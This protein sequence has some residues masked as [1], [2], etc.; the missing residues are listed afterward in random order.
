[1]S[2]GHARLAPSNKRWP[3][4]PGSVRE[5]AQYPD[6]A[7]AAAVDGTG[8]HLL[9]ELC[10]DN[11][12]RPE[13]Y[14]GQVIGDGHEDS[15]MGWFVQP[16]RIKRVQECLDYLKRRHAEL[17]TEYPGHN[18]NIYAETHSDPGG[19][20]G[21]DDWNGTCDVT[22]VVRHSMTAECVFIEVVDYKDG[23]EFVSPHD[24]SQLQSYLGGK[25]RPYI[26]SGPDLVR[27]LRPGNINARMT[28]VQPKT[29]PSVRYQDITVI[30]FI[31][32]LEELGAAAHRTDDPDAPLIPDDKGGK[33][34]CRW[35][36]HRQNCEALNNKPLEKLMDFMDTPPAVAGTPAPTAGA[37]GA[38]EEA[39]KDL[40]ALTD[41]RLSE[42][43]DLKEHTIGLFN[44]VDQEIERRLDAGISVPGYAMKPGRASRVW[45]YDEAEIE[46]ALKARRLKKEDIYPPK[47][48][49][50]AQIMKHPKLTDQQKARIEKDLIVEKAGALKLTRVGHGNETAEKNVADLFA[51][52]VQSEPAADNSTP[53][54]MSF[55]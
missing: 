16:D 18:I 23:R 6:S 51:D 44:R 3:K 46:K 4:C 20:F 13:Q 40:S 24:N 39:I 8:S 42:L 9:L 41:A 36:K 54:E 47:L 32:I 31:P 30:E 50:P 37:L 35:C 19:I 33:G 25:L 26:A 11:N 52:V 38:L 10:L 49:S 29:N 45:A 14:D 1:M 5:E 28:I 48:A 53:P 55:L 12:V 2:N 15:P 21:R 17:S 34:H 27:P 7:G 22:I 43:A